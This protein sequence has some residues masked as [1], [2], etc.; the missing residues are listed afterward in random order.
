MI[1]RRLNTIFSITNLISCKCVSLK[2]NTLWLSYQAHFPGCSLWVDQD[3]QLSEAMGWALPTHAQNFEPHP[4]VG[5]HPPPPYLQKSGCSLFLSCLT[6]VPLLIANYMLEKVCLIAFR[7]ILLKKMPAVH[8]FS[9]IITTY[10]S[11]LIP[12]SL[13]PTFNYSNMLK[14]FNQLPYMVFQWD[15]AFRGI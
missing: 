6:F 15:N 7:Q 9:F 8:I 2:E 1:L 11:D 3:L 13:I 5:C 12:L 10:S 4:S 14:S